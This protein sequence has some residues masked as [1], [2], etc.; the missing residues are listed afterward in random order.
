MQ[1]RT[2]RTAA[3][4]RD[5][6]AEEEDESEEKKRKRHPTQGR[7]TPA[8]FAVGRQSSPSKRTVATI[9]ALVALGSLQGWFGL[10][11]TW[12]HFSRNSSGRTHKCELIARDYALSALPQVEQLP[13]QVR[14]IWK[15]LEC[16]PWLQTA[17]LH[18][19]GHEAR[20]EHADEAEAQSGT[21]PQ[22]CADSWSYGQWVQ[23]CPP[24]AGRATA[25]G[26][27]FVLPG[28]RCLFHWFDRK[29]TAQCMKNNW[30]L[31][32]GGSSAVNLGLT[33]LQSLDPHGTKHP[34]YGPRWY[35]KTCWHNTS[36]PCDANWYK[37]NDLTFVNFATMAFDLVMDANGSVIYKASGPFDDKTPPHLAE[38]PAVPAGGWR[39]TVMPVQY[40][41]EVVSK[42]QK[43]IE[44]TVW[45]GAPPIVY[46][47]VGQ[48]YLNAFDG[49]SRMWGLN[50]TEV[51]ALERLK[52]VDHSPTSYRL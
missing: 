8:A 10:W 34:F 19:A 50:T 4:L 3:A 49:R 21:C 38:A 31:V 15:A 41:H 51:K 36:V 39:L 2:Q 24:N 28:Q 30:I 11:T 14:S 42:V 35:N 12:S 18:A 48:W 17:G 45:K 37:K 6:T 23:W 9:A 20:V 22:P 29:E 13:H 33:W 7:S 46:A 16:D 5:A 1:S 27:N 32:L 40:A 43:A 26:Y 25:C 52:V 44:P 47:Q